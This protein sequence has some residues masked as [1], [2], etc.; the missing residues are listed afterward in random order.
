MVVVERDAARRYDGTRTIDRAR[1]RWRGILATLGVS[2]K[3]LDGK[4]HP[5]PACGGKDRFR[6][7]DQGDGGHFCSQCGSGNG[8]QLLQKVFGWDFRTTAQRIDAIVGTVPAQ[9]PALKPDADQLRASLRRLWADSRPIT[10]DDPVWRYLAGRGLEPPFPSVLRYVPRMRYR[11]V[12]GPVSWHPGML[13]L[14]SDE[15]GKPVSLHRTYL[16]PDGRKAN[17]PT[18][19]KLMPGSLPSSVAVRLAPIGDE[20]GVAEGIETAL[21][22]SQLHRPSCWAALTE[23]MLRTFQPPAGV[24]RLV[25]FGDNDASCVGQAAAFDLARRLAG[26][27]DVRVRIPERIG[28]DWNDVLMAQRERVAC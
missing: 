16:T 18:V 19:R 8:F 15:L 28:D 4:H 6:Y 26:Y 14:V 7:T 2:E 22:A 23:R 11:D 12:D 9:K 24:R 10:R 17:V 25:V 21:A 3:C 1:G 27:T 20:L 13:A 5:C